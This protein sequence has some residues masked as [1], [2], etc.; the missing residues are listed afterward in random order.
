MRAPD[1]AARRGRA[2]EIVLAALI[3]LGVAFLVAVVVSI[4]AYLADPEFGTDAETGAAD[5]P[6]ILAGLAAWLSANVVLVT[7]AYPPGKRPW[8]T[9]TVLTLLVAIFATAFLAWCVVTKTKW[10]RPGAISAPD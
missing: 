7:R 2:V 10:T 9:Y 5:V 8:F 4:V 3:T 6:A 1:G